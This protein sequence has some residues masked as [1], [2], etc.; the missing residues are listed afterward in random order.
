MKKLIV[1]LLAVA[2]CFALVACGG[3]SA[4]ETQPK[5]IDPTMASTSTDAPSNPSEEPT[6][7]TATEPVAP[8]LPEEGLDPGGFGPIF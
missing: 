4:E 8:T 2:A 3:D 6:D 7:P 1:L 5:S